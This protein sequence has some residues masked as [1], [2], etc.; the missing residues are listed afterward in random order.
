M[1]TP[2]PPSTLD[3]RLEEALSRAKADYHEMPGLR[4]TAPQATRLW[5]LDAST[6]EQVLLQLV[7]ERFLAR[8]ARDSYVLAD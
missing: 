5:A 4:L 7:E 1:H 6:C 2:T 3:A 8:A